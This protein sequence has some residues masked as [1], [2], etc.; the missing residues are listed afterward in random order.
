MGESLVQ[1][2]HLRRAPLGLLHRSVE[3]VVSIKQ[4]VTCASAIPR[5]CS[6]V[7][8]SKGCV[9]LHGLWPLERCHFSRVSH[10]CNPSGQAISKPS[11]GNAIDA[12]EVLAYHEGCEETQAD[13]ERPSVLR[14]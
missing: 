13:A 4:K 12:T 8:R 3:T 10:H 5:V 14:R 7:L 9:T 11:W 1:A 6:P 2:R